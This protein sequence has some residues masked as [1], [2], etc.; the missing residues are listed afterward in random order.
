MNVAAGACAEAA[1]QVARH[2][3]RQGITPDVLSQAIATQRPLVR[4][5]LEANREA[6]SGATPSQRAEILAWG[7]DQYIRVLQALARTHPQHAALLYGAYW[8]YLAPQMESAKQFVRSF[9][10]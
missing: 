3:D 6:L 4:E 9:P 1:L 10:G 5:A 8:T 2:F 7:Q